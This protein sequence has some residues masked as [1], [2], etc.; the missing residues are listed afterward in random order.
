MDDTNELLTK[1]DTVMV[2]K[3]NDS[4][5]S[6]DEFRRLQFVELSLIK[7][8]DR[9]CRAN[10]IHYAIFAGTQLGAV[11]NKG[12]IPW[13]D[14]A[15]IAML[16]EDYEKFKSVRDQLNPD[17]CFFQ[18][19]ETDPAYLWEFGKVRRKGT[20][21]MR[22]G[23]EHIKCQNGVYIDIFPLDDVPSSLVG[24][25]IQDFKCF[26]LRKILWS[27]VA[28]KTEK[29]VL[30]AWYGLLSHISSDYVY[31][32]VNKY[33]KRSSNK[34]TN[35]VRTLLFPAFGKFYLKTNQLREKY[36]LKKEWFLELSDYEFEGCKF[37]G[38]KDY[39][40]VLKQMYGDYM[41]PPPPEK[42]VPK[43]SF[44]RIEF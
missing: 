24:Q 11:R 17:I 16:R 39:D 43:V 10:G 21:H 6:P 27:K 18:D 5:L 26:I 30:K 28:C 38:T 33:A 41:T 37:L 42:R 1:L 2:V 35:R 22:S 14:D 15:D 12:F 34:T 31:K 40:G 19:H 13:D 20:Y 29:G 4:P 7:E 36:G 32:Q 9:V 25:M 8:V 23:Q 3:E 44:S